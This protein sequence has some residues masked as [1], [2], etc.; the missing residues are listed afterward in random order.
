MQES[1]PDRNDLQAAAPGKPSMAD[2]VQEYD[3]E[4]AG[5]R[6]EGNRE[7]LE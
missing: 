5:D 6:F 7:T 4:V 3:A 2:L 1:N